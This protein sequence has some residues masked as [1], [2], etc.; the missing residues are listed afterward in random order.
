MKASR[1]K[2]HSFKKQSKYCKPWGIVCIPWFFNDLTHTKGQSAG[3][4]QIR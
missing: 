1:I 3:N 2:V 4:S